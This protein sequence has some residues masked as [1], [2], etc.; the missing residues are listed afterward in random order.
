MF[1][2]RNERFSENSSN[3][4]GKN[5][6]KCQIAFFQLTCK[7]AIHFIYQNKITLSNTMAIIYHK[8]KQKACFG[9]QFFLFLLLFYALVNLFTQ[10]LI[11]RSLWQRNHL[12]KSFHQLLISHRLR[13]RLLLI[14]V[15][16]VKS[17]AR[18][19]MEANGEDIR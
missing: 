11:N 4:G 8:Y 12:N 6:P 16:L 17:S 14:L 2:I 10:F 9:S 15:C 5:V 18:A 1:W 19:K 3:F 7:S 13:T